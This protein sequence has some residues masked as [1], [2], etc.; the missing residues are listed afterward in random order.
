MTKDEIKA[1]AMSKIYDR[2][3]MFFNTT[4][5]KGCPF[6]NTYFDAV[7]RESPFSDEERHEVE[8]IIE[9]CDMNAGLYEFC[10][11]GSPVELPCSDECKW[12]QGELPCIYDLDISKCKR[13]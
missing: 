9:K 4:I 5:E 2:I 13:G 7:L 3:N 1:S 12:K 10:A 11:N 8:G 6:R